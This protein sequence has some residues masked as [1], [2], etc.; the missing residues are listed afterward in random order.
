MKT[1]IK[2]EEDHTILGWLYEIYSQAH[3]ND[4]EAI[5]Q[6]FNHVYQAMHGKSLR[7]I[8]EVIYPVCTLCSDYA[9]FAFVDGVR[10]GVQLAIEL[11]IG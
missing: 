9:R 7:E 11:E 3:P 8:D 4:N 2:H 10:V 6:D 5:K 1:N